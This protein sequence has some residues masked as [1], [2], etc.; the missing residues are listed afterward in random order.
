MDEVGCRKQ[1]RTLEGG[2]Q[3]GARHCQPQ[4]GF[5]RYPYVTIHQIYTRTSLAILPANCPKFLPFQAPSIM[6]SSEVD[7]GSL[8]PAQQAALEQY[9]AVTNQGVEAA[10]PLLQRTQWNVQVGVDCCP[11]AFTK[12]S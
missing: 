1:P 8:S 9:T 12:P 6:S 2:S 7:I 11:C 3:A 4:P 10:L 5:S